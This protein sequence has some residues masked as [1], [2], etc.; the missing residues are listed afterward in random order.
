MVISVDPLYTCASVRN[1]VD[2]YICI[3]SINERLQGGAT[4]KTVS[5]SADAPV[6]LS[7]TTVAG[8]VNR[9]IVKK[10]HIPICSQAHTGRTYMYI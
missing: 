5:A 3:Y 8:G 9:M 1:N 2:L 4:A 6:A 10:K 7:G